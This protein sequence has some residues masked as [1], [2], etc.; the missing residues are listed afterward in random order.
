MA[1]AGKWRKRQPFEGEPLTYANLLITRD[2][3][4]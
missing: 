2:N 1:E 4:A 3:L